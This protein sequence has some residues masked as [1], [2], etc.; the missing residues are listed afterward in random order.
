M[1]LKHYCIS[2]MFLE[3]LLG[4]TLLEGGEDREIE[5]KGGSE[6]IYRI[7]SNGRHNTI[8]FKSREA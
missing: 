4:N 6:K 3:M 1:S 2:G 8:N 7:Y 5:E